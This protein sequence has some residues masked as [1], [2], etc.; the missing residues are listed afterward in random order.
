MPDVVTHTLGDFNDQRGEEHNRRPLSSV[1]TIGDMVAFF[2]SQSRQYI[3]LFLGIPDLNVISIYL[4]QL[5]SISQGRSVIKQ[6][7]LR[8]LWV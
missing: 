4:R 3:D 1:L 6:V 8:L 2:H 7:L 5:P